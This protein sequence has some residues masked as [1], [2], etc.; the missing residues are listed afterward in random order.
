MVLDQSQST[1]SS[2][3]HLPN[4]VIIGAM[5]CG[6]TSLH[7]YLN[8][9][10]QIQMSELKELDFFVEDKN[11]KLGVDWYRSQFPASVDILGESS[12]NYTKYPF[13]SGVPER[14]HQLIPDAKLIYLVRDPVRRVLSHYMHQYTNRAEYRSLSKAFSDLNHNH[15]VISSRYAFQLEQFLSFYSLDQILVL[16][17]EELAC[18]PVNTLQQVFRFLGVDPNFNHPDFSQVFHQSSDKQRLTDF[19]ATLF[20]LPAGGRLLKVIPHLMAEQ[21]IP[22]KLDNSLKQQLIE[23]LQPDV[24]RLRSLTGNSFS[25]WSL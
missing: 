21:V 16:S 5:K 22:P 13:F 3:Q 12:P 7:Q 15:Y 1:K 11:W 2:T 17:L 6:T 9:H 4:L 25:A 10:P 18:S 20:R 23:I 19:G 14:M 24:D 8:L